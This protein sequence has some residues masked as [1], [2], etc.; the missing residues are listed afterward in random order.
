MACIGQI[1]PLD[2]LELSIE[3]LS[4]SVGPLTMIVQ[5]LSSYQGEGLGQVC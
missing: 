4:H 2:T 1:A 3:L 5:T